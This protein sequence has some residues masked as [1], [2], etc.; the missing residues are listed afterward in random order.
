[1]PCEIRKVV[2]EHYENLVE[3][4]ADE[5]RLLEQVQTL[6]QWLMDNVERLSTGDKWVADIGFCVRPDAAGGGPV[7]TKRLMEMCLSANVEV[8]LSEYPGKA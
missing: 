6:E 4:A 2:G 8:F 3:L 7:I 5:W 1:L